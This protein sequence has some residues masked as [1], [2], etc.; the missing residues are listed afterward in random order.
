MDISDTAQGFT[1]VPTIPPPTNTALAVELAHVT[2]EMYKKNFELVERNKALSIL[3]KIHEIIL[4]SVTDTKQIA[5][6][7][8][9]TVATEA[10]FKAVIILMI[11]KDKNVLTRL[12]M[13]QTQPLAKSEV[14]LGRPF[15]PENIS[16][17]EEENLVIKAIKGKN[18]EIT[19]DLLEVLKPYAFQ[20]QID[21]LQTVLQIKSSLIYPFIVRDEVIGAMIICIGESEAL[22]FQYQQ[23]LIERLSGVV[24]IAIDNAL[25]YK[26][27]QQA[28]E[29]LQQLDKL[30]DEFV[31]LASHE[32]RTPMT[33]I[34]SYLWM[35]LSGKG[36]V[37]PEKLKFYLDR[38]Y[39][40]TDR[41]I[42][43]VNDMLNVSRIESGR[44]ILS[45]KEVKY[46][47]LIN[48]VIAEITPRAQ[49]LGIHIAFSPVNL[50]D[51][52][53]DPDKLKE[54]LI[55]LIGNSL[56]FTPQGGIITISALPQNGMILTSVKDT[57]KGI[58]KEDV[59]K[60]FQKFAM[61]GNNYLVKQDTQG[62]G[63]GLY[64]SKS[65]IELHGG[66]I[67]VDSEGI[68]KGT[69]FYFTLKY[70]T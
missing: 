31:S 22:L 14:V 34:K 19:H 33:A 40:S 62:T 68:D 6:Q 65:L 28:N 54:V 24:G 3:R 58:A 63:L 43:L 64:I 7:V 61:L 20:N 21:Q 15:F 9:N 67:W 46:N 36:G 51:V 56:K 32:L 25:L 57:G 70:A 59:P 8:A 60:L 18:I 66:K 4:S 69:T 53:A 2:Q 52:S 38:A 27:L 23:D 16:L 44:I 35:A 37:L 39:K 26:E 5:E 29:M 55:N 42:K 48:E 1:D 30:K 11:D 45:L 47:D 12:A 13:S 49:E 41:L 10:E 50:S 17:I